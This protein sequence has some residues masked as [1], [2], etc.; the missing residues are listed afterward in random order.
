MFILNRY[1]AKKPEFDSKAAISRHIIDT[2]PGLSTPFGQPQNKIKV[3]PDNGEYIN[4]FHI[5]LSYSESK[6][7]KLDV[8]HSKRNCLRYRADFH[9][10]MACQ[11]ALVFSSAVTN[12]INSAATF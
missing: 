6:G 5:G 3:N 2:P 12:P 7:F 10:S 11:I 9:R 4:T 1:H 8:K